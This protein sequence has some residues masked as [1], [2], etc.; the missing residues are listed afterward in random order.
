[1]SN[2]TF[3]L[4]LAGGDG[5]RLRPLSTPE[6]PKQFMPFYRQETLLQRTYRRLGSLFPPDRIYVVTHARYLDQVRH[7][8]PSADPRFILGE[9]CK[10]N[11]APCIALAARWI[12]ERE[13]SAI[14]GV[15]SSDHHIG[16]EALFQQAVKRMLDCARHYQ[17]LVILGVRPDVPSTQ[18]GYIHCG[19][20]FPKDGD[21]IYEVSQFTEKP[22]W[23]TACDFVRSGRTLWNCGV[24]AWKTQTLLNELHIHLNELYKK[25]QSIPIAQ[26]RPGPQE[27]DRYFQD[28]PNLSI[29][30]G[31]LQ[32]TR[33]LIV[34]KGDFVWTDLGS[35]DAIRALV[36]QEPACLNPELVKALS[37][38]Q[39]VPRRVEKPWGYELVWTETSQYVG[40]MLVIRARQ[41]LSYQFHR[42]KE[43]SIYVVEGEL[44]FE[45]EEDGNRKTVIL[46]AGDTFHIPPKMKHRMGAR[47]D[48]RIF[49]VS[50]P[51]LDDVV[52][53]EDSYGRAVEL[54]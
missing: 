14:F 42:V 6:K 16:D 29:D 41:T 31:L 22:E 51:H 45:F 7:D 24:F 49:E 26:G 54:L 53:L 32:K 40:K 12:H 52:R 47:T 17:R 33:N 5:S 30:Y 43:E 1:M 13:P 4:I 48:C 38:C 20:P 35:F 8:L 36:R 50:T 25:V 2:K 11:T 23:S 34:V 39:A 10:K 15:F 37:L 27:L 3:A 21:G 44:D 19:R 9:S 46:K 18:Y 28:A